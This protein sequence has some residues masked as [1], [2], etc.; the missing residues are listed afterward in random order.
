MNEVQIF[1]SIVG[2]SIGALMIIWLSLLLRNEIIEN[3]TASRERESGKEFRLADNSVRIKALE[4]EHLLI[5]ETVECEKC[6]CLLK[7][8]TAFKGPGEIRRKESRVDETFHRWAD[9]IDYIHY[10][11]Y[12]K[13]H[14][15][16]VKNDQKTN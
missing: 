11:Y 7:K 6:G 16:K 8:E 5:P 14:K 1:F 15:P 10:P 12:C 3:I 9:Y 13:V 4:I 2:F